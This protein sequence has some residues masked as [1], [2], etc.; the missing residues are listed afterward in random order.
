[1]DIQDYGTTAL[2]RRLTGDQAKVT[3]DMRQHA[4][5]VNIEHGVAPLPDARLPGTFFLNVGK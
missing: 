5:A 1:M 3:V 4:K 2:L